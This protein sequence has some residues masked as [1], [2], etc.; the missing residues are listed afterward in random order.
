[1]IF[2]YRTIVVPDAALHFQGESP[3]CSVREIDKRSETPLPC[4]PYYLSVKTSCRAI[5][6]NT[7]R[8]PNM[9]E[10]SSSKPSVGQ[11]A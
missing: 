10:A 8:H 4:E 1:M 2:R 3:L 5:S 9:P 11:R 6:T 7:K